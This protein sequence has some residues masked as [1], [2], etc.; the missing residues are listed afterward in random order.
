MPTKGSRIAAGHDIYAIKAIRIPARGQMLVETGIAVGLLP[1]TYARLAR[2]SGLASTK[3]IDISGGVIDADYTGEVKVIMIN[4][5]N[6]DCHIMER[7]RIAQIII[8]KINISDAMEVD[9]LDDTIREKEG[10]GS[11][12]LSPKRLVQTADTQPVV[13]ILHANQVD[14]EFFGQEDINNYPRLLLE[15]VMVSCMTISKIVLTN[16]E[17]SL[18]AKVVRAGSEDQ[19][20]CERKVELNQRISL[21]QELL[22][23]WLLKDGMLYFK[24]RLYIPNNDKLKT[25]IAKGCHDSQVAGHFGMEKTMEIV[26]RDF[27]WD[28]VTQWM[29][30]Y[31]RSCDECQHNKSPRYARWGLL[32]PLETPY[33]AW[34][35]ISTDFITQLPESQGYTQVMVVVNRFTKM[36]HFISL[37]TKA[38]AKDLATVFL[39]EVLKLHGLPTEIISDM[40]AKFSRE[41]WE[42]LCKA[43]GIKRRM[44]TAY[45]SQTDGQTERT[46]QVLEGYLRNLV[47][48]DQDD[49][50][51]LLPLAEFAYNNSSTNAHRLTPFY[52]NYGF[53]PQ[54]EWRKE[55]EAQNYGAG[56]FTH[57]MKAVHEKA[58]KAL[59][60]TREAMKKYYDRKAI[61]QPDLKVGDQVMLNAKNIRTK[62][63]SKKLS[64]KVYSL[65][66]IL[67]KRGNRA[68]TLE[69][70]PRCK[71]QPVIH[72]SL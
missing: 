66:K 48:Y 51:Q 3:G 44:S 29:N 20:W 4:H 17:P 38:T 63:P 30:D 35:S 46:N 24:N 42:S 43:L 18:I 50:Y 49:W 40:D 32:Q 45:H 1:N 19:E 7:E 56:L 55:C 57:W 41:F 10:F 31:V 6:D 65:F 34:T 12:N 52:A 23:N 11:T 69:I 53:H 36:A 5:S 14:N 47:N 13:C 60:Q 62:R 61:E 58:H 28:K 70:S 27:Y 26:S 72:V 68:F 33:A 25:E 37:P 54:T 71:I 8:E 2:R 15:Q 9:K 16:Y 22:K 64:Q 67:E 21:R 39:R 59:D